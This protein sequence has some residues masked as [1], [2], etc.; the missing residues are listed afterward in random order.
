MVSDV[1]KASKQNL[2]NRPKEKNQNFHASNSSLNNLA[3]RKYYYFF[4]LETFAKHILIELRSLV[5]FSIKTSSSL[6]SSSLV[7]VYALLRWEDQSRFLHLVSVH[8]LRLRSV[9][10]YEGKERKNN[11]RYEHNDAI[12]PCE[13]RFVEQIFIVPR[14]KNLLLHIA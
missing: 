7:S 1:N 8:T 3:V 2:Y 5:Y 14:L 13:R 9:K 6:C 11:C 12:I 4:S 10:T